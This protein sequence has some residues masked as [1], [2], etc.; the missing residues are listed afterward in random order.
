MMKNRPTSLQLM[1]LVL[2][3]HLHACSRRASLS[4]NANNYNEIHFKIEVNEAGPQEVY[5]VDPKA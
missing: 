2:N 3:N 5:P 1:N 4:E